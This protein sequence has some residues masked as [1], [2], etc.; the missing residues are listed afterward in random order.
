MLVKRMLTVALLTASVSGYALAQETKEVITGNGQTTIVPDAATAPKGVSPVATE[1]IS[2]FPAFNQ[3]MNDESI[4]STLVAQGFKKIHIL[5]EGS[6]MTITG[7]R[8]DNDIN[9]VYNLVEGRLIKVNG[10]RILSDAEKT[11]RGNSESTAATT[12]ETDPGSTDPGATDPGASGTTDGSGTDGAGTGGTDAGGSTDG[13]ST[14]SGSTDGSTGSD[15]GG[16]SAGG[17][18]SGSD[19]DS[20]SGSDSGSDGGS[21]SGGSDSGG[22]DS[23]GDNS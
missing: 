14:D 2:D 16:S 23:D 5:R 8:N 7:T 21:G 19:S 3:S 11:Q 6:L 20:D 18:D 4:A 13:G 17:S 12:S 10:E 15:T 22:S 9:L 1:I